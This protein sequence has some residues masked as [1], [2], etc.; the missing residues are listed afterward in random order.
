MISEQ[1]TKSKQKIGLIRV[2]DQS[3]WISCQ[4]INDNLEQAY[5]SSACSRSYFL[6]SDIPTVRII[7]EIIRDQC[8]VIVFSDHRVRLLELLRSNL[9]INYIKENKVKIIIHTFGCFM[10]RLS[11]YHE[12]GK[13]LKGQEVVF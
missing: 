10:D 13:I 8:S 9:F 2:Q 11:E 1:D 12:A 6:Y 4:S 3:A 7:D 5:R